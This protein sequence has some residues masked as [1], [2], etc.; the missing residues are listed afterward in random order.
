MRLKNSS[1]VRGLSVLQSKLLWV[2]YSTRMGKKEKDDE[3][4]GDELSSTRIEK[5]RD[6]R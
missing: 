4:L 2:F 6:G 3:D 5:H 1:L